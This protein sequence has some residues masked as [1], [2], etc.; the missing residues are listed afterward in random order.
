MPLFI[1]PGLDRVTHFS[2]PALTRP[3]VGERLGRHFLGVFGTYPLL[4]VPES[5]HEKLGQIA[6]NML[7]SQKAARDARRAE[8]KHPS[9]LMEGNWHLTQVGGNRLRRDVGELLEHSDAAPMPPF[10]SLHR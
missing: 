8:G 3:Q 9:P 7:Y 10:L 2:V 6:A 5:V 4:D 1:C